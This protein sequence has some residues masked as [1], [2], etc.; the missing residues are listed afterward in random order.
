MFTKEKMMQLIGHL[1]AAGV[2]LMSL[3]INNPLRWSGLAVNPWN[4]TSGCPENNPL[5]ALC[6]AAGWDEQNSSQMKW[7]D[8]RVSLEP[9]DVKIWGPGGVRCATVQVVPRRGRLVAQFFVTEEE[10]EELVVGFTA[11]VG[12]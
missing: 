7:D 12:D 4:V 3:P 5:M 6:S 9:I 11:Q 8:I 2:A 10:G 1:K